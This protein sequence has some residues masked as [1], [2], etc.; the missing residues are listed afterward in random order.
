M[1][2]IEYGL[3]KGVFQDA[4]GL[5]IIT[6]VT[7]GFLGSV[8]VGSGLVIHKLSDGW[9]APCAV[10][11]ASNPQT[12]NDTKKAEPPRP[13]RSRSRSRSRPCPRLPSTQVGTFGAGFGAVFGAE[14][15][16]TVFVL[17]DEASVA[18]FVASGQ[19]GVGAE[20]SLAVGPWGRAVKAD[21]RAAISDGVKGGTTLAY[22]QSRG[23]YGGLSVEGSFLQ[24]R[25][26][27]NRDFYGTDLSSHEILMGA[28]DPPEAAAPLVSQ[29]KGNS[30]HD[31]PPR[32]APTP[33]TVLYRQPAPSYKYYQPITP[34]LPSTHATTNP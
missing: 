20:A 3:Q 9:S 5:A 15:S 31:R 10:R 1:N 22:S 19:V 7:A 16:D 28:V 25:K 14:L 33:A 23:M 32:T 18:T 26:N 12:K 11:I 13:R 4:C 17:S 6:T 34:P 29:R 30:P 27:V 24:V 2:E 21:A 8:R